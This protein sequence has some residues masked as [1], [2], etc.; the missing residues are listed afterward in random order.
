[1]YER[2]G[3]KQEYM[4]AYRMLL[5]LLLH[6]NDFVK[7]RE[8]LA[9]F[10]SNDK[11]PSKGN[12]EGKSPHRFD[13]VILNKLWQGERLFDSAKEKGVIM[14]CGEGLIGCN[15]PK[16]EIFRGCVVPALKSHY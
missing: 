4:Y 7:L 14:R 11:A 8:L 16:A 6:L 12:D 5:V 2:L 15:I 10:A 9:G 13:S 1:M 3:L